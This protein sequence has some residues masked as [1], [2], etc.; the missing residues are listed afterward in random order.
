MKATYLGERGEYGWQVEAALHALHYSSRHMMSSLMTHLAALVCVGSLA[1][2]G[3][4]RPAPGNGS[5]DT[6][7]G[8]ASNG[9]PVGG[10]QLVA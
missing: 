2:P 10:Q 9:W 5:P 7:R 8:L 6:L 1:D 3:L 4:A